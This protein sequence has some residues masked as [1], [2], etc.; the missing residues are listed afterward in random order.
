MREKARSL[1]LVATLTAALIAP[2]MVGAATVLKSRMTGAQIVNDDG[3]SP[4]G[5]ADATLRLNPERHRVCFEIAYTGLGGKA[6]AGYLRRGGRGETAPPAVVLFAG[7]RFA[8]PVTGCAAV[9]GRTIAALQAHPAAHYVDL[10]TAARPKGAV[11]GQLHGPGA[12][13]HEL[14]GPASGGVG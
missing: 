3:G 4:R 8:S 9:S 13:E 14:D 2:A 11:R 6:T 1:A 5:V 10:A 7:A 12:D